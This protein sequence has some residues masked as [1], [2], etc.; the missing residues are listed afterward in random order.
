MDF[1]EYHARGVVNLVKSYECSKNSQ[2]DDQEIII[3]WKILGSINDWWRM[4]RFGFFPNN[5]NSIAK[6]GLGEGGRTFEDP[7]P[8]LGMST[9]HSMTSLRLM[10]RSP[11]IETKRKLWRD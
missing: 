2:R 10:K 4:L 9:G 3:K 8:L 1:I 11:K 7:L 6:T 5:V